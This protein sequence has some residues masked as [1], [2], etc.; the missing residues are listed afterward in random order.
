MIE[1]KNISKET[2]EIVSIIDRSVPGCRIKGPTSTAKL[3][4]GISRI[5]CGY[6]PGFVYI[7][8]PL[9]EPEKPREFGEKIEKGVKRG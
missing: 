1:I 5:L 3:D 6:E 8:R 2:Y 4:P 7:I 9:D